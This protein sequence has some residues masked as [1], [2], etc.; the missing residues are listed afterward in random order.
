MFAFLKFGRAHAPAGSLVI[1][2]HIMHYKKEN[3]VQKVIGLTELG[4]CRAGA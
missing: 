1:G 2:V 3:V 4:G